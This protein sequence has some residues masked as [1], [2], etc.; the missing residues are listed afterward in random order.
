MWSEHRPA[1][2]DMRGGW[3]HNWFSNMA[4]SNITIDG[5]TYRSVENYYQAMK[6]LNESEQAAI[7][8]ASPSKSKQLGRKVTLRPDWEQ[9]KYVVM[10]T[11]LRAK[12]NQ[13]EWK[14]K[15]LATGNEVLIE[16]NNWNDR[17]WGVSIA[18]NQG[19]NL[20]GKAL[21]EIR[22]ELRA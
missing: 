19:Q 7:A 21:E 5:V 2:F 20:L 12:F 8:V 4:P 14:D 16:W 11:A 6:T 13:P 3:V 1:K 18:D 10:K 22:D 9:V 17:I 15:L